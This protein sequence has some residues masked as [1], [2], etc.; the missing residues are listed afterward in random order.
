MKTFPS[1]SATDNSAEQKYLFVRVNIY[2]QLV[3]L[4]LD[5]YSTLMYSMGAI[6]A[7]NHFGNEL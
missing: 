6:I 1:I 5:C 2:N 4:N 7:H 3:P